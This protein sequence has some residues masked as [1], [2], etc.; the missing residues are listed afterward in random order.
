M[1][2]RIICILALLAC[3]CK[4]SGV[5]VP[6]YDLVETP[7]VM[8][9]LSADDAILA[10]TQYCHDNNI[11]L[12]FRPM[13]RLSHD[14][15]DENGYWYVLYMGETHAVGSDFGLMIDDSTGVVEYMPGE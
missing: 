14:T 13:P 8:T 11:D 6:S 15:L 3:G 5:A 4:P 9:C 10:A 1:I 7:P 2:V 12:R